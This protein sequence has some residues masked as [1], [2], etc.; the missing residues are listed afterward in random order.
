[1]GLL[2]IWSKDNEKEKRPNYLNDEEIE[3]WE[4]EAAEAKEIAEGSIWTKDYGWRSK[5]WLAK[6]ANAKN[7]T[8]P[9][10]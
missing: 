10:S 3:E 9:V 8:N 4:K 6:H 7:L 5:E 1:M 2:D